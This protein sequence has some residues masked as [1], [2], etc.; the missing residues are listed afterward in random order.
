MMDITIYQIDPDR[1][2]NGVLFGALDQLEKWQSSPEVD[3]G[4]YGKVFE[5]EIDAKDLEEIY[6]IFNLDKPDGYHGR[7]LSVSDVVAVRDPGSKK[8]DYFSAIL[9]ASRRLNLMQAE[10]LSHLRRRSKWSCVNLEEKPEL[11]R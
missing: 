3:A 8:I 2:Q 1:D 11:Q 5:G 10:L 4:I 9:S 6:E 7:S